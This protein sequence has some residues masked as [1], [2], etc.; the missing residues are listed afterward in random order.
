LT[1][2]EEMETIQVEPLADGWTVRANAIAND[3]VFRSGS[4]AE[5]AARALAVRMAAAGEPVRLRVRL[6]NS[7]LAARFVCMPPAGSDEL[8]RLIGLPP[9]DGAAG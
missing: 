9:L 3:L 5:D 1:K 6:R 8:P 4:A 2:E 7:E